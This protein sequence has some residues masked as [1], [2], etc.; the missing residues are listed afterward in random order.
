MKIAFLSVSTD[1]TLKLNIFSLMVQVQSHS[2]IVMGVFE[3]SRILVSTVFEED[4]NAYNQLACMC[5][6]IHSLKIL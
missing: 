5:M 6:Y 4:V 1:N 3:R 2:W